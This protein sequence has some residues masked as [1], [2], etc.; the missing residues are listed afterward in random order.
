MLVIEH[1]MDL[2]MGV[3]THISVLDYGR[4]IAE[5]TPSSVQT[6]RGVIEAY[7]G[8]AEHSFEDLR[9]VRVTAPA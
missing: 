8:S 9:R 7:L 1:H 2:V 4:K 6:D 3:S 5:G